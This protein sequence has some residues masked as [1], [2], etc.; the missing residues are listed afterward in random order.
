MEKVARRWFGG[1][2]RP[3]TLAVIEI[4]VVSQGSAPCSSGAHPLCSSFPGPTLSGACIL[5][6]TDGRL[7]ILG[8]R[9][10][11]AVPG[12]D[13]RAHFTRRQA[14]PALERV[15]KGAHLL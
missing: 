3:V 15:R 12:P 13:L 5:D 10:V 14:G 4:N 1:S 8:Q 2:L 6:L 7:A 11:S 9:F